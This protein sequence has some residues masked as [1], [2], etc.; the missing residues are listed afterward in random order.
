VIFLV[1]FLAFEPILKPIQIGQIKH[2]FIVR[3]HYAFQTRGNLYLVLEYIQGGELFM[4]LE[5]EG[6]LEEGKSKMY[7]AQIT[8]ALGHLHQLGII[9]RDLKPENI[10]LDADGYIKLID[11]GLCKE[12]VDNGNRTFTYCGTIEYMAPEVITKQGHD[13]CKFYILQKKSTSM[14][15]K[16]NFATWWH[17]INGRN[18]L[19]YA[20]FILW[21]LKRR[22]QVAKFNFCFLQTTLNHLL[23]HAKKYL[24][25]LGVALQNY[26]VDL[27][28]RPKTFLVP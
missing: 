27:K 13:H 8:L 11:F 3:L 22:H 9:F 14:E 24:N 16:N 7:L 18:V 12:Q 25:I 23:S 4:M 26:C 19:E 5:R 6:I 17:Y 1:G 15:P 20:I 2:P 28:K 10:M 21:P